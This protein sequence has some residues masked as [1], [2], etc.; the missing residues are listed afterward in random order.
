ML[1]LKNIK[2]IFFLLLKYN[3]NNKKIYFEII[4]IYNILIFNKKK[5]IKNKN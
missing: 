3:W 4:L 5:N 1:Y 2:Y